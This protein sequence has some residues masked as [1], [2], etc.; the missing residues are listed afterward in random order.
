LLEKLYSLEPK[1]IAQRYDFERPVG[2][3]IGNINFP[4]KEVH[5]PQTNGIDKKEAYHLRGAVELGVERT[6]KGGIIAS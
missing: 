5:D 1:K 6:I 3:R 4:S 2:L